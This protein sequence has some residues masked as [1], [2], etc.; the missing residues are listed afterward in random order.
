MFLP[1]SRSSYNRSDAI[2]IENPADDPREFQLAEGG[3]W[4]DGPLP[5]EM[6]TLL[7]AA[8]LRMLASRITDRGAAGLRI[9]R[10]IPSTP[11]AGR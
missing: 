3:L 5:G 7:G 9:L 10:G 2:K 1:R 11:A 6:D 8:V 4:D